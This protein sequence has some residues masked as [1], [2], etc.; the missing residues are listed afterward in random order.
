MSI[1]DYQRQLDTIDAYNQ[2]I[3][4][5]FRSWL[6]ADGLSASTVRRH[7]QYI[8][9]FAIYLVY[10]D[11]LENLDE[12]GSGHIYMFLCNF[13]PRKAVWASPGTMRSCMTALRKFFKFM[14]E[15]GRIEEDS[16][17]AVR[18][19]LKKHKDY[20]LEVVQHN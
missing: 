15:S 5:D 16:E 17:K 3:L 19:T 8:K 1:E 13:F 20:F 7:V 4:A 14:V 2:P 9:F 11:P 6:E 18:E 12:A 10:Y